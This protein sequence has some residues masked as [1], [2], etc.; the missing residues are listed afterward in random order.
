[1]QNI[2]LKTINFIEQMALTIYFHGTDKMIIKKLYIKVEYFK[3][4]IKNGK[5]HRDNDQPAV[6]YLTDG[7][8]KYYYRDDKMYSPK[9]DA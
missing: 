9:M 4:W 2:G 8:H 1:M 7:K 3:I 5:Y 6:I